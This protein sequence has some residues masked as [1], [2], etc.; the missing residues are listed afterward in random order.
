MQQNLSYIAVELEFTVSKLV[1]MNVLEKEAQKEC[2]KT[3]G[4]TERRNRAGAVLFLS[5][6]DAAFM[7]TQTLKVNSGHQFI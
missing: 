7:T 4:R 1:P 6:D 2:I 5:L 3:R